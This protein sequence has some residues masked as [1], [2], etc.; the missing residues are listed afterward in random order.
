VRTTDLTE[1]DV[2]RISVGNAAEVSV[3]AL[4]DVKFDGVVSEIGLQGEDYR[5]DVVYEVI[6][7]FTDTDLP[8]SLRWGMTAM[9]EIE[10]D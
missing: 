3:D 4:P 5:G 10:T 7:E 9:V 1:L 2:G 6:V 8:E